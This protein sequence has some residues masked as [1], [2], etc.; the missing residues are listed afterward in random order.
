MSKVPHRI[1]DNMDKF[2]KQ[3]QQLSYIISD[4]E[5]Y[6]NE[7]YKEFV[8]SMTNAISG[9][10]TI[11]PKM[12]SAIQKII[13]G[14]VKWRTGSKDPKR[15]E[16]IQSIE[17]KITKLMFLVKEA[18][19]SDKWKD[20]SLSFLTSILQGVKRYG[21]VTPKQKEALNKMYHKIK[22]YEKNS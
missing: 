17:E 8:H 6:M 5:Y 4:G 21:R 14:Y 7:G 2:K 13:D 12:E 20:S 15:V 22:I 19:G 9:G 10:R 3:H 16:K 11:T 18:D 1:V